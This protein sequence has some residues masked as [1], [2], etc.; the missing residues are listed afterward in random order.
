MV[1]KMCIQKQDGIWYVMRIRCIN[2]GELFDS[3]QLAC[4][5]CGLKHTRGIYKH[6]RGEQKTAGKHPVTREKL[7]WEYVIG[8]KDIEGYYG[9]DYMG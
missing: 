4:Q 6:L 1:T 7:T 3:V 9:D 5:W 2:T 8:E